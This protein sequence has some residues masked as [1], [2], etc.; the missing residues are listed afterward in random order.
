MAKLK[1]ESFTLIEL[2]IVIAIIGILSALLIPNYMGVRERARDTQRKSDLKNI[3]T[4]LEMYKS[5]Q[6]PPAYPDPDLPAAGSCWSSGPGCTE[7]IYMN[8]V[9]GD[10]NRTSK[11]YYY[12]VDNTTLTYTLCT[13]LENVADP[14]ALSGDCDVVNYT[15]T[16]SG[17][18]YQ[19]TQP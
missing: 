4:A 18:Y 6:N 15:C 5:D 9:P 7:N 10:P 3:Q 14:D 1:S 17:K 12:D 16:P 2:L 19:L 13:C 8:K 11:D